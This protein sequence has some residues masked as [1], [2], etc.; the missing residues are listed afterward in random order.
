[1][2]KKIVFMF[3]GQGSQYYQ[4]G[5]E[6]YLS[7][8]IFKKYMKE[9]D[10]I[11][12]KYIGNSI[13]DEIYNP[14]KKKSDTFD[15][16][17]YTHPAIFMLEY[18]LTKTLFDMDIIPDYVLGAS[19]GEFVSAAIAKTLSVEDALESV[20]KQAQVIEQNCE[21]SSMIAIL[22]GTD[23]YYDEPKIRECAEIGSVNYNSH[24]IIVT[25]NQNTNEIIKIL[26]QRDI[27][28][29]VLPV[30]YGFHSNLI[31][32]AEPDYLDYLARLHINNPKLRTISCLNGTKIEDLQQNYF[33]EVVNKPIKFKEAI[34]H[35]EGISSSNYYIDLGPSG[36]LSNFA[37]RN[38]EKSSESKCYSIV[39]PFDNDEKNIYSI[40]NIISCNI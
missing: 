4:M 38:I 12:A 40:K 25:K 10:I 28:Y 20:I 33:W 39:T 37:K 15:R 5:K 31:N 34:K 3:S 13:I 9:L 23:L 16:L 14:E 2:T 6:L 8:D 7:N 11:S 18:S 35:L 32:S 36:T 21:E 17:L 26:R 24:F 27:L 29:Q 30:R 22:S 1:M 19:L